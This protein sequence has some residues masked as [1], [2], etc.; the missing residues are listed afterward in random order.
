MPYIVSVM[1]VL[2]IIRG[3]NLGIPYLSPQFEKES[4]KV[5]C[6]EKLEIG[7]PLIKCSPKNA[8]NLKLCFGKNIHTH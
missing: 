8:I 4:H 6:C 5:S 3:L 7:K 1:A 2:L